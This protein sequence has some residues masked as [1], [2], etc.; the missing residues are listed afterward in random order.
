MREILIHDMDVTRRIK[1]GSHSIQS[2]SSQAGTIVFKHSQ[3]CIP[4]LT[5]LKSRQDYL[6]SRIVSSIDD[7][8]VVVD[9]VLDDIWK[10]DGSVCSHDFQAHI[11]WQRVLT[12]TRSA[13]A[14]VLRPE[15]PEPRQL[16]SERDRVHKALR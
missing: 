3:I 10:I 12:G 14:G 6:A 13:G 1:G 4:G 11:P 8:D 16:G 7:P 2:K 9:G 5:V 15:E